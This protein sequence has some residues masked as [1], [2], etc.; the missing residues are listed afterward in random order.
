MSSDVSRDR[1]FFFCSSVP[2]T[3][4]GVAPSEFAA[5]DVLMP[6]QPNETSSW[7]RQLSRQLP[8]SPPYASGISMFISPVSHAF[9][10]ISRGNSPVSSWWPAFGMISLRVNSRAVGSEGV[11][12]FGEAEVH[13][14]ATLLDDAH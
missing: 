3:S 11:L 10:R 14:P 12:L 2:A 5:I 6:E 13:G 8:P 4:S 1:Y 9:F 7:T